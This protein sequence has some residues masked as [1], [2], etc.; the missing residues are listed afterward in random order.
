MTP[1][2]ELLEPI[3]V[4]LIKA[5]MVHIYIDDENTCDTHISCRRA[6]IQSTNSEGDNWKQQM[7]R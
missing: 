1:E 2:K 3:I 5:R 4:G 7:V 6:W